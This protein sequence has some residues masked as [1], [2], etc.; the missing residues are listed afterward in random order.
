MI[1]SSRLG[2]YSLL[3]HYMSVNTQLFRDRKKAARKTRTA[4]LY[5]MEDQFLLFFCLVSLW[6][7]LVGLKLRTMLVGMYMIKFLLI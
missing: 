3:Y 4:F 2:K 5:Q 1:H 6:A 7:R